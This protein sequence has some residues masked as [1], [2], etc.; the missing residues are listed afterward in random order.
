[1][2]GDKMKSSLS[3]QR[4]FVQTESPFITRAPAVI[5]WG[6]FYCNKGRGDKLGIDTEQSIQRCSKLRAGAKF[7]ELKI[8]RQL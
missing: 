1:M 6:M 5:V 8:Y 4:L 2:H 3:I 7:I